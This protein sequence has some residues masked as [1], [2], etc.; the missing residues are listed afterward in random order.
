MSHRLLGTIGRV[1]GV[2]PVSGTPLNLG[3]LCAVQRRSAPE[4]LL[5]HAQDAPFLTPP[6]F[7]RLVRPV[8]E[9]LQHMTPDPRA[10]FGWSGD[11]G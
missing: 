3:C 10:V 6:T 11:R 4:H 2:L 1:M 8:I 9:S 7:D 5:G